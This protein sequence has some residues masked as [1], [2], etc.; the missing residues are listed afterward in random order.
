[1]SDAGAPVTSK[2]ELL[3]SVAKKRLSLRQTASGELFADLGNV[4]YPLAL[5]ARDG[6]RAALRSMWRDAKLPGDP[7]GAQVINEVIAD[8]LL[9]AQAA[10]P[11]PA[12]PVE[13]ADDLMAQLPGRAPALREHP[14]R[15]EV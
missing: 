3:F 9:A 6:I 12:T 15:L 7:P 4:S 1:M 13:Q 10:H 2:R 14:E 8:L 5:R 11:E